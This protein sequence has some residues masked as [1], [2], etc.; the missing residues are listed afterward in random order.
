MLLSNVST[1]VARTNQRLQNHAV[2]VSLWAFTKH[3]K[4][5]TLRHDHATAAL[6]QSSSTCNSGPITSNKKLSYR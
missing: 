3:I 1:R 2:H 6:R 5:L 4:A